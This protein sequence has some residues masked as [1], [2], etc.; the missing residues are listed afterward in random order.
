MATFQLPIYRVPAVIFP[1]ISVPMFVR[2]PNQR[3]MLQDALQTGKKLGL[4]LAQDPSNPAAM[5]EPVRVGT[6]TG[7]TDVQDWQ[8]RWMSFSVTGESR[9]RVVEFV[10]EEPY[11]KALVELIAD[12]GPG[13]SA[14]LTEQVRQAFFAYLEARS[15]LTGGWLHEWCRQSEGPTLSYIMGSYMDALPSVKQSLLEIPE[16]V[17]RLERELEMLTEET[18]M[19]RQSPRPRFRYGLPSPN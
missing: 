6:L 19:L 7:V 18:S 11:V 16:H 13:V 10:Q 9:F 5:T 15:G 8:G 12:E 17:R 4:L 14:A 2:W 1:G 3:A